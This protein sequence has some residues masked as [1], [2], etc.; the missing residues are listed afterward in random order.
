[1]TDE[2]KKNVR[3]SDPKIVKLGWENLG[4]ES[5]VDRTLERFR[6]ATDKAKRLADLRTSMLSR[7]EP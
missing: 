3:R 2:R 5:L 7:S 4:P 1:M 6:E